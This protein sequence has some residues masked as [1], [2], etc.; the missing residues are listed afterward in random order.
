MVISKYLISLLC[1]LIC[2]ISD[3]LVRFHEMFTENFHENF[4]QFYASKLS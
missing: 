1:D 3:I 2:R 4:M